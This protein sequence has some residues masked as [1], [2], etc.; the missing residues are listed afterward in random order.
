MPSK[1]SEE[2]PWTTTSV[3]SVYENPWIEVE[4]HKVITPTQTE[5]I[6]G[7][8]KMKNMAI[9]IIPLD[10]DMNT[11]LVGQYRY[12]LDE[13]SWE[14][15]MGG[16]PLIENPLESAKRELKEETGIMANQWE[17]LMKIHT[18]NSVTDEE[19]HIY[20]AKELSFG[21]TEFDETERIKVR[22][23]PFKDVLTMVNDGEITDSISV[24]GILKLAR[25]LHL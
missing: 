21:E 15:P 22:K 14:I 13:Y 12:T 11:W 25:L 23:L 3:K 20:V 24:C 9:G 7:K 18:S 8:V 19:G 1:N 6:Y 4:H 17:Y 2:N 16:G 5:G 10:L